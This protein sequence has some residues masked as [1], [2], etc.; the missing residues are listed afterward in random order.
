MSQIKPPRPRF[1]AAG[2]IAELTMQTSTKRWSSCHRIR[3]ISSL[4]LKSVQLHVSF[5][6]D[7]RWLVLLVRTS[8]R[9]FFTINVLLLLW[10]H[11]TLR[12]A[13]LN[14]DTHLFFNQQTSAR[15]GVDSQTDKSLL[16]LISPSRKLPLPENRRSQR[17]SPDHYKYIINWW[18]LV[19]PLPTSER[20]HGLPVFCQHFHMS[21]LSACY[22]SAGDNWRLPSNKEGALDRFCTAPGYSWSLNF[23]THVLPLSFATAAKFVSK[24]RILLY[25]WQTTLC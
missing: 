24:N 12:K 22:A 7:S 13:V 2:C 15:L 11:L 20:T 9:F 21:C 18:N 3:K 5:V 23:F 17:K 14:I 1:C 8:D 16:D 4:S 6:F 10:W 25:P 19:K